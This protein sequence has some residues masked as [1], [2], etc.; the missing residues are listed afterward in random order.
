VR[1]QPCFVPTFLLNPFSMERSIGLN[2]KKR[3]RP[4]TGRVPFV[5]VRMTPELRAK[6]EGWAST[7]PDGASLSEAIRRLIESA[8][9]NPKAQKR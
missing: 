9:D 3:G 6:I 5:G 7:Q 2:K 4:K 1:G 8:L